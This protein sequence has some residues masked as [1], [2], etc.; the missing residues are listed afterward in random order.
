MLRLDHASPLTSRQERSD[1]TRWNKDT[2]FGELAQN[3]AK[4]VHLEAGP[5]FAKCDTQINQNVG[6]RWIGP[7]L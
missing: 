6:S 4:D 3:F 7:M 5:P 2:R 1:P